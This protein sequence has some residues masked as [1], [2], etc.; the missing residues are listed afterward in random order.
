MGGEK[1]FG[2]LKTPNPAK[3]K[4]PG[5]RLFDFNH[6]LDQVDFTFRMRRKTIE[7]NPPAFLFSRPG[8]AS[9]C[10]LNAS[11]IVVPAP[12]FTWKTGKTL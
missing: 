6:S 7:A 10:G 4:K 1:I 11:V 12:S 8:L 3:N 9:F 5:W 2:I